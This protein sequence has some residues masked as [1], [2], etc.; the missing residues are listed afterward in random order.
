MGIFDI[1]LG[2]LDPDVRVAPFTR[3][4]PFNK[5]RVGVRRCPEQYALYSNRLSLTRFGVK[6][7]FRDSGGSASVRR[8]LNYET[9]VCSVPFR[10][11]F[12]SRLHPQR[13]RRVRRRHRQYIFKSK[14]ADT[15]NICYCSAHREG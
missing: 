8:L 1:A 13:V 12:A 10:C 11:N 3:V 4:G 6:V 2:R 14:S 9:V 5:V 7:L 15:R